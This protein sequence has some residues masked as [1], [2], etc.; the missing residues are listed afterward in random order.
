MLTVLKP[1]CW[2]HLVMRAVVATKCVIGERCS[3][4]AATNVLGR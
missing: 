4:A 3:T 1:F 2:A